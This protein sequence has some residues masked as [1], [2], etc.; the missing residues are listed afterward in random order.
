[1]NRAARGSLEGADCILLLVAASGWTN[2]DNHGLATVREWSIPVILVINKID[3]LKNRNALLPFIS[4]VARH[5]KF[6]ERNNFV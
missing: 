4:Q 3:R 6:A 1:M 2:E 5:M